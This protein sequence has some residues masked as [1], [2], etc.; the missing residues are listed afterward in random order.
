M[1]RGQ[2]S[3][4]RASV[5]HGGRLAHRQVNGDCYGEVVVERR[6][7]TWAVVLW[8][9][10]TTWVNYRA[11]PNFVLVSRAGRPTHET[12]WLRP[13]AE[14][15]AAPLVSAMSMYRSIRLLF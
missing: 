6:N 14:P 15:S 13:L 10:S 12:A 11:W 2:E 9:L 8:L 1:A 3:R 4:P 7:L 5:R